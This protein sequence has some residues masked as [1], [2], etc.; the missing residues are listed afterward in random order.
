[1]IM[2]AASLR[3]FFEQPKHALTPPTVGGE[4]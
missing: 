1:V 2:P 3:V 4:W